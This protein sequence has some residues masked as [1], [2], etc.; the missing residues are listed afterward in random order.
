MLPVYF[1]ISEAPEHK[2][3][4]HVERPERIAAIQAALQSS[5]L[6]DNLN[7]VHSTIPGEIRDAVIDS[8]HAYRDALLSR[9]AAAPGPYIGDTLAIADFDDPDGQTFL[10]SASLP[11]AL[12]AVSLTLSTLSQ[13][14]LSSCPGVCF[15]RPP[16]H[17]ATTAGPMGYCLFNNVAAAARYVQKHLSLP[18]VMILDFDVHHGNGTCE[19]FD[20]D[21][22]VLVLDVHEE[23]AVY[24]EYGSGMDDA[25][26]GEGGGF[27]INVP[28]PRG[29]GHAS[30]LKVWDDIVAPA[31]ERFRPDL[32][33]VSA[34]F[35]AHEDDPFQLLCY[36]TETY[37]E[38]ASRLCALATRLCEGRILFCL[39]GGYNTEA[40]AASVTAVCSALLRRNEA[41][42]SPLLSVKDEGGI[43]EPA[44]L[45]DQVS[46][47]I[48]RVRQIH[49]LG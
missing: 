32:I 3:P 28:L 15:L 39:E 23:S 38:L 10:T 31:A 44:E 21:P 24:L 26:R 11:L 16:G 27:T 41:P 6:L 40:L 13:V 43:D 29:A 47:V 20:T 25:G 37:G 36:R 12:Q 35:D 45:A 8:V 22:S 46:A 33:L 5:G 42:E 2:Q 9:G 18:K 14:V 19:I 4:G 49:G 48:A 34:G 30:V 17:H 1:T 7:Q